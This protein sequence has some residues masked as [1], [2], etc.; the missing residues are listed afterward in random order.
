MYGHMANEERAIELRRHRVE[1]AAR[2]YPGPTAE[3]AR[4]MAA[5]ASA[6]AA[7]GRDDEALRHLQDAEAILGTHP[8]LDDETLTRV[9]MARLEICHR[10]GDP[11]GIALSEAVIGR[12]GAGAPSF[13]LLG[14]LMIRGALQRAAGDPASAVKSVEQALAAAPAVPGGAAVGLAALHV[15]LAR[16]QQAAGDAAGAD[17]NFR[18]ALQ[19][20]ENNAGRIS[21]HAVI[22]VG[23]LARFLMSQGQ[24]AEAAVL[25][26]DARQRLDEQPPGLDRAHNALGVIGVSATIERLL[27][28]PATAWSLYE[29]LQQY[30][31][32]DVDEPLTEVTS[33]TGRAE[34]LIDLGR[35]AEAEQMLD[36]AAALY[37]DKGLQSNEAEAE[38]L[39]A[40]LALELARGDAEAAGATSQ[41]YSAQPV[42][43]AWA[44]AAAD[45]EVRLIQGEP[46]AAV[47]R[48]TSA[49]RDLPQSSATHGLP[50]QR[51]RLQLALARGL[52]ALGRPGEALAPLGQALAANAAVADVDFS[53]QRLVA[54]SVLAEA[55]FRLGQRD[56]ARE[57]L[58]E[59]RAIRARHQQ[60][61]PQYTEPLDRA[62]LLLDG[63]PR[64]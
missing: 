44:N 63:V 4:A 1:L 21:T 23:A 51:I 33:R 10:R 46:D 48:A 22:L 52:V 47:A 39:A 20:A 6:L 16:S 19:H 64:E 35:F 50:F 37:R 14:A 59:A 42:T 11:A 56:A 31:S 45:A 9:Q 24:L 27:G 58:A 25:M 30:R 13:S 12:L 38:L 60:L 29:Q 18:L 5:L 43:D 62:V 57:A 28:H 41:R 17:R 53:P 32:F 61:G 26:A 36:G 3:R 8:S 55:R 15:E 49:L 40:Q 34:T 7:T 2:V 54:L